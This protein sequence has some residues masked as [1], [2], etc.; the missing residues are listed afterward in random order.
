LPGF[1]GKDVDAFGFAP[2]VEKSE[3][4]GEGETIEADPFIS[5]DNDR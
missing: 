3:N 2:D 5:F 1:F 4:Q